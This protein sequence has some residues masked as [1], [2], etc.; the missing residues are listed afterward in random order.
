MIGA[1]GL[2]LQQGPDA[3]YAGG[4]TS[5]TAGTTA[6]AGQFFRFLM[7][8]V[9]Q[10]IQIAGV[11]IAVPVAIILVWQGWKHRRPL[12]AWWQ[13][14][15]ASVK[16]AMI[17]A[18]GFV[19][20]VGGG[21]GLYGYNY[22]MHDND[23]CQSCHIMDTAWNRFQVS[24]HKGLQCHA[25]HRQPLYVSSVELFWWVTRRQM[26]VPPHDKVPTK[27]CDECH[28][29]Q[30]TD[31]ARTNVIL[32]AGHAVHLK[33]DSSALKDVQC[34][35]CHG[36]DFHIFDPKNSTCAQSG[37][38]ASIRVNLGAMS[39]QGFQHCTTCHNFK[40]AVPAGVTVTAAKLALGP[41]ALDCST[42][43]AMTE[44]ILT[45]DLAADPHKGNCGACH[46]AHKQKEPKD[47]YKTC[48]T[49]Q[50]HPSADTL[51]AF[52]RGVGGHVL[53]Q[54]GACHRAHSWKVKGTDCL[55]CHKTIFQDRPAVKRVSVLR[56]TRFHTPAAY[57]H[58]RAR[59]SAS[60]PV[61]RFAS[62]GRMR[63]AT[64]ADSTFLHSRH[65]SLACTDCHGTTTTHGGLKF[66][67]PEGCIG[68]HHSP[69]QRVQCSTCHTAASLE[70]VAARAPPS[71]STFVHSRHASIACTQCHG[72]S[73]RPGEMQFARNGGCIGCH[74][75]PN[76]RAQ[77]A[78]CHP[79]ASLGQ[80]TVPVSFAITPR[81]DPVTR[82]VAFA[83][84]RHTRIECARCHAT[85]VKR[86]VMPTCTTCH[87]DHHGATAQCA[88]CHTTARTGH[89]RAA[90]EGCAGCHS[91]A[92]IAT[93]ATSRPVCLAC[94]EAQ[95]N[96][97]PAGDCAVCHALDANGMLRAVAPAR[98]P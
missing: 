48:A 10:W 44:K 50:C 77:C 62:L 59:R 21:S 8:T 97:Y 79:V 72:T 18:V 56:R 86:S 24:A 47:A 54:C 17:G 27:V 85:D 60:A 53:D 75:G 12:W 40:N 41:K 73:P 71:S 92:R 2:L 94:H 65:K 69:N 74:H 83:H 80:Y 16:V 52:H 81:R 78:T 25:C 14:R 49:A 36:R 23:F 5:K 35:T 70:A 30:G 91:N 76:Q 26:E 32:T 93:Q 95:K 6:L 29:R 67:R 31:S 34:V 19:G 20:I 43:H 1:L 37:C 22:V 13:A 64:Q 66:S 68:C 45:F 3:H 58:P 51:T 84:A 46:D 33:S 57:R 98:V 90:H 7:S 63:P 82:P 89:D 9:P 55:A 4:A 15:P 39:R 42:C 61:V 38:H 87:A 96:H 11:L 28:M 88:T